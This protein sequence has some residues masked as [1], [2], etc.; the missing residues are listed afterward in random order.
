MSRKVHMNTLR[1]EYGFSYGQISTEIRVDG[2][3]RS[4][5]LLADHLQS[6]TMTVLG[7]QFIQSGLI[8]DN[9]LEGQVDEVFEDTWK[10][11]DITL[12]YKL[13]FSF[14]RDIS[15]S[16]INRIVAGEL[17]PEFYRAASTHLEDETTEQ[18]ALM[19]KPTAFVRD[20]TSSL[21]GT[22]GV[23]GSLSELS[24]MSEDEQ[25]SE[26][27]RSGQRHPARTH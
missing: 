24:S 10:A 23:P 1:S 16:T 21:V 12:G 9:A 8:R 4:S 27:S 17:V 13:I 19:P 26:A 22:S 6:T 14:K 5:E 7:T 3:V 18:L 2:P 11:G 20:M 25:S 15:R